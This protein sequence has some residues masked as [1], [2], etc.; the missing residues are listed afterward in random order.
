MYYSCRQS[1]FAS[2][3]LAGVLGGSPNVV[4]ADTNVIATAMS[5]HNYV[6]LS[7][8]RIAGDFDTSVN[9]SLNSITAIFGHTFNHVETSVSLSYLDLSTDGLTNQTGLGDVIAKI[10]TTFHSDAF[11][12]YPAFAIKLPTA[13]DAKQLGT[14]E[15]DMGGFL[16]L[17][18]PCAA[19]LCGVALDYIVLGDPPGTDY[20]NIF[21]INLNVFRRF[22]RLGLGAFVQ[23]ETALLDGIDNPQSLG[24]N[25]FYMFAPRTAFYAELQ[26]GLNNSAADSVF[27]L[28]MVQWF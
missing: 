19:F 1:L 17:T 5:S 22:D 8:G 15:V 6:D 2:A 14:G 7:V 20:Q 10:G 13:D 12:L 27:R 4:L 24:L 25:A 23:Q 28:G 18:H 3:L 21:R 26:A 16:S 11:T 9:S